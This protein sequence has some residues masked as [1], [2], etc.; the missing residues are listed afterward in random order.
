MLAYFHS[1]ALP[2]EWR[3]PIC[4][5]AQMDNANSTDPD[6]YRVFTVNPNCNDET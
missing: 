4:K 5:M 3:D 1:L 6:N 2:G